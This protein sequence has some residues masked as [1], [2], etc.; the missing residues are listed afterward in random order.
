[1][2]IYNVWE[3]SKRMVYGNQNETEISIEFDEELIIKRQIFLQSVD[4]IFD[5]IKNHVNYLNKTQN[6]KN[7][8]QSEIEKL[9]RVDSIFTGINKFSIC[10]CDVKARND[11]DTLKLGKLLFN[12]RLFIIRKNDRKKYKPF[13]FLMCY[14]LDGNRIT[15]PKRKPTLIELNSNFKTKNWDDVVNQFFSD[16][17]IVDIN[18]KKYKENITE[19]KQKYDIDLKQA[20]TI[21]LPKIKKAL[22]PELDQLYQVLC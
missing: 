4:Y 13:V 11:M 18:K 22:L 16:Q 2:N 6:E 14:A 20:A 21:N 10:C 17:R 12:R 15:F 8:I 7:S 9:K 19:L 5:T 1:M 3:Y